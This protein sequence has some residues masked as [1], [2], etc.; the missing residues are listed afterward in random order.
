M[1]S[2]VMRLAFCHKKQEEHASSSRMTLFVM[3]FATLIFLPIVLIYTAIVFRAVRGVVTASL[4]EK[5][6]PISIED[7]YEVLHPD[8]RHRLRL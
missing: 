4:I 5:I 1:P 7:R 3:L 8:S 2:S 6:T